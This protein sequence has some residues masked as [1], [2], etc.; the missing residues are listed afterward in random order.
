[1]ITKAGVKNGEIAN[2][3]LLFQ[4]RLTWKTS[5]KINRKIKNMNWTKELQTYEI[6]FDFVGSAT[7]IQ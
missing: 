5:I 4:S 1:M 2:P 6:L 3:V 7:F